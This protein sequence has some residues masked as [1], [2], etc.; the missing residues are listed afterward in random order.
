MRT[1][2]ASSTTSTGRRFTASRHTG[3]RRPRRNDEP[4]M[5]PGSLVWWRS[6][7]YK[8][9]SVEFQ[10]QSWSAVLVRPTDYG[11]SGIRCWFAP[12]AQLELESRCD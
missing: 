11:Q 7:L 6:G 10:G 4:M 2:I 8:V 12:C 9:E 1:Q 3:A 5:P